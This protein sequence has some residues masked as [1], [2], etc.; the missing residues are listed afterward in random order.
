MK[1]KDKARIIHN[2]TMASMRTYDNESLYNASY[3]HLIRFF[4]YSHRKHSQWKKENLLVHRYCPIC[5][6]RS[7]SLI[8]DN[9]DRDACQYSICLD[10]EF[11]YANPTPLEK[12]YNEI[13]ESDYDGLGEW[14]VK[15]K[16]H[17]GVF[18]NDP[19]PA[20]EIIKK[21]KKNGSFLDFGCGT[22][23][24]LKNAQD[25]Y[26]VFGI[27]MDDS[28]INRARELLGD[29]EKKK[30]KKLYGLDESSLIEKFDIVYTNQTLEH[31]LYPMQYLNKFYSWL[32]PGGILYFSCPAS[33]S[34]AFK[35]LGKNNS[36]ATLGHVSLFN[37]K[38]LRYALKRTGFESIEIYHMCLDITATEFWKKI[39]G[40]K[41]LH[42]HSFIKNQ[43][44]MALLYPAMLITTIMLEGLMS[45]GILKGNYFYA[46]SKK[47][48]NV[49]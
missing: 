33:D 17:Y 23:W 45:K 16:E 6:S 1:L 22:G 32:K 49:K 48:E 43:F 5:N 3:S 20:L 11:V 36:M 44:V 19:D 13:Y 10:C 9:S 15:Q 25:T 42:R 31:V 29:I 30:I 2:L 38:S 7:T 18:Q 4:E 8:L 14:W 12:K 40:I 28:R 24:T 26:D 37:R 41:F 27:D 21:R 34:F 35:F 47:P 39:C 46:F